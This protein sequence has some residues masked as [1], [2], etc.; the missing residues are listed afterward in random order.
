MNPEIHARLM[1]I[2]GYAVL[3]IGF[4]LLI[5]L[6]VITLNNNGYL[7]LLLLLLGA[8]ELFTF[9]LWKLPVYCEKAGCMGHMVKTKRQIAVFGSEMKYECKLCNNVYMANYFDPSLGG[10]GGKK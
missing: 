9:I 2:W 10:R 3:F 4:P 1:N 5:I 8:I 7:L 6:L